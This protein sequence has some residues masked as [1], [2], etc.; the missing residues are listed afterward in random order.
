MLR[1]LKDPR[2]L[3]LLLAS[4]GHEAGTLEVT[5]RSELCSGDGETQLSEVAVLIGAGIDLQDPPEFAAHFDGCADA[6]DDVIFEQSFVP[7]EGRHE[8]F[9]IAGL[10]RE[11]E[12]GTVDICLH[13]LTNPSPKNARTLPCLF[14]SRTAWTAPNSETTIEL[15]LKEDCILPT[16]CGSLCF[17]DACD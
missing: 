2:L 15:P 10:K 11:G 4:C 3:L 9:V 13:E 6:S 7:G 16:A 1:R 8:L 17:D 5:I 12:V 14:A